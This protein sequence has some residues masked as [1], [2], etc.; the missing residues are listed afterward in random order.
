MK[1]HK[2]ISRIPELAQEDEVPE[3][4]LEAK[5]LFLVALVQAMIQFTFQKS[6]HSA[7]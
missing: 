5:M 1:H 7:P 4:S 3:T 6:G 2:L